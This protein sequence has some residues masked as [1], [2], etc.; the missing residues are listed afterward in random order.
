MEVIT[1]T[2]TC[3][4]HGPYEAK[5]I[6]FGNHKMQSSQCPKCATEKLAKQ[7]QE[8][9]RQA[10]AIEEAR[11]HRM[12]ELFDSELPV[13]FQN[14]SFDNYQAKNKGQQKA[15]EICNRY[16]D[17]IGGKIAQTGGGLIFCGRPGTGK[18]H[19]ALA[20]GRELS[21][22]GLRV[23]YRNLANLVR[24]VR[25]TWKEEGASESAMIKNFQ[26]Y[27]LLIIDE[28]GVQSGT[29]N[30]RNIL[31]EIVNGRYENVR[32]TIII[33]NRDVKE[34]AELIS[35]RSVD[36][37]TEGGAIIPFNWESNRGGNAA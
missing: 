9:A 4:K 13:R 29:D 22:M 10:V 17:E 30:E 5:M 2:I 24:E 23:V 12:A 20:I 16:V 35:E 25:S 37:I 27:D 11:K 28:I 31:F 34:V 3:E 7:Q 14:V 1:K 32:P 36:R 19:L 18:T 33:S 21:K 6:M 15:K 8:E 26:M